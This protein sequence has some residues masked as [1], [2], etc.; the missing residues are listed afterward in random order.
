MKKPLSGF[1]TNGK[2]EKGVMP[3]QSLKDVVPS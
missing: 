3:S 1:K 2:L